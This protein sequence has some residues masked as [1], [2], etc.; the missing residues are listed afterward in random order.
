VF[1]FVQFKG[2]AIGDVPRVYVARPKAIAAH[3][4]GLNGGAG[5]SAL[6][7]RKGGRELLRQPPVQAADRADLRAKLKVASGGVVFST[8]Q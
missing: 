7:E 4:R 3:L 6:P 1:V 5:A 8:I 2:V